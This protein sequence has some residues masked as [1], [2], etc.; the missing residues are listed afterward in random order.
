MHLLPGSSR[1]GETACLR[2]RLAAS[3]PEAGWRPPARVSSCS[4]GCVG[5]SRVGKE[6]RADPT[7]SQVRCHSSTHLLLRLPVMV[8]YW[9]TTILSFFLGSAVTGLGQQPQL[10][11]ISTSQGGVVGRVPASSAGLF[12]TSH[13]FPLPSQHP[14]ECILHPHPFPHHLAFFHSKVPATLKDLD[15]WSCNF[16]SSSPKAT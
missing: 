11:F 13:P 8:R 5:V 3:T 4:R 2:S 15:A 16:S 1:R 6:W 12:H 10:G 9:F 14:K 7:P